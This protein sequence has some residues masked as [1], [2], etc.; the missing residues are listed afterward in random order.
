[1]GFDS[2]TLFYKIS[3]MHWDVMKYTFSDQE[4]VIVIELLYGKTLLNPRTRRYITHYVQE[5][6]IYIL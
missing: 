5:E 4:Y 6:M 1:M 2:L 3:I